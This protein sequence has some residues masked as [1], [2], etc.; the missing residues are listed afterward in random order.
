VIQ[1]LFLFFFDK[2]KTI[3]YLFK[4]IEYIRYNN[5]INIAKN[6][7][8]ETANKLTAS[9]LIAYNG[10]MPTNNMI[11]SKSPEYHASGSATLTSKSLIESVID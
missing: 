4:S 10:K 11:K 5:I 2:S 8:D 3:F 6:I 7:K 9:K 1:G